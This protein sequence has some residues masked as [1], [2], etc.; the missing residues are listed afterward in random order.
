MD[1]P[2]GVKYPMFLA[3]ETPIG[4]YAPPP[5]EVP[6]HWVS[7]V[8]VDDVDAAAQ[9]VVEA[10]GKTLMDAFDAPGVGRMQPAADPEGAVFFLFKGETNDADAPSGA[11]AMHWNELLCQDPE[12]ELAFYRKVLG[13]DADTMDMPQGPYHILK[14]GEAMRGGVMKAPFEGHSQW[15]QYITVD[16]CDA[17]LER[18]KRHGGEVV[19]D[20]MEVDGIGRF[21]HIRDPLGAYV[22]VIAPAN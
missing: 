5:A 19:S 22:A 1:M 18:A 14:N 2:G 13:Y 11:G 7:Y 17:A 15:L 9:R 21:A 10:G 16:D 20:I 3:G 12:K 8:S 6:P 4:G